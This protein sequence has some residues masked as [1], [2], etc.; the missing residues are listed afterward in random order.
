[1]IAPID[2]TTLPGPAQKILAEGASPRLQQMAAKGIVPGLRPD[3][4]LSVLVLLQ[5]SA[6]ADVQEAATGTLAN[7]P[8]PLLKGAIQADLHPAVIH[9]LAQNYAARIDVLEQVLRMP[10]LSMATVEHLAEFGPE[11]TTELVATNQERVLQHPR[12]I[13]LLYLNKNTRMSTADRLVELAVR[14]GIELTGIPA[15]REASQAIKDE[16]IPEP[17]DEPLPDDELFFEV[18]ELALDLSDD[19]AE[20]AYFED[21]T[22]EEQLDDRFKPLYQRIAEMSVSQKIRRAM[23]GTK[24][25]R[26][27]LIREQNKIIATA[28]A[29]SPMMKEPDVA[30]IARNRGVCEDVLRIIG[31]T[32][33]WLKSYQ[34]K[35]ALVEN[36]KT[37]IAIANR[38]VPYLRE[39]DLRR[40]AR[41]K[42]VS[43]AVQAAARRHLSRRKS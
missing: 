21:D 30:L 17:S 19:E 29:R 7:L 23:L 31:S 33:E 10:Q 15:W 37:P 12:I 39:A 27:M 35:Q 13:E 11:A 25:E 22:G 41:N 40:L 34:I 5:T 36:A 1:M 16:L 28:A 18:H 24:E 9:V 2:P 20:D 43:G 8:E 3:A 38:L 42:N 4:L 14:G 26:M 32:P 6:A